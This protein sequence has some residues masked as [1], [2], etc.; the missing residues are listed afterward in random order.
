MIIHCGLGQ[1]GGI[2]KGTENLLRVA[3]Q[4]KIRKFVHMS[5]AAVYGETPP[6]GSENETFP[7]RRTGDAY[8][9]YKARAERT[10]LRFARTGLPAVVLRPSIVYGPYSSWNTNILPELRE[11]R[12]VLIDGG[13]GACNTTYVDNLVD[14]VFLSLENERANGEVFFITD[15]ERITWG[16]F[17]HAHARLLGVDSML[18]EISSAAIRD[19]YEQHAG[20]VI[21]SIKAAVK[22]ARS[23]EFR[24]ILLQIPATERV[25]KAAWQWLES[26]PEGQRERIRGK[27]G[28]PR[29]KLHAAGGSPGPPMPDEVTFRTQTGSVFFS[30]NKARKVLGYLP[31]IGFREGMHRVE[32]WLRFANAL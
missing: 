5:T 28:V 8:C 10:V 13:R 6:P 18:P 26:L 9:D 20:I 22:A 14:A 19:F 7:V 29:R 32:Q 30:I 2:A 11:G 17:I 15:G 16:D 12:C 4:V 1:A 3:G 31:R 25:L 24:K 21:G 27:A 23:Q